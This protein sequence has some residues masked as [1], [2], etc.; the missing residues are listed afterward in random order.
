[1]MYRLFFTF[2]SLSLYSLFITIFNSVKCMN[3]NSTMTGILLD[4][5]FQN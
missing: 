3:W 5:I 4:G 2:D 1:M